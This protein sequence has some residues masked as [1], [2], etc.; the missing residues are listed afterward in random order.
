MSLSDVPLLGSARIQRKLSELERK[1]LNFDLAWLADA[2]PRNG[3][4]V[5]DL[6]QPLPAEPPG[7]PL[8]GGS[9]Q[10]AR[11]LMSGYEFADPSI[12][13]AYYDPEVP[14]ARR[15]ML[16]RL[17]ALGVAHLFAGV[18]VGEVY[19]RT[20]Q[21]AGR[22]AWVWGWN[23]R[24]LEGH[25]EMGQMDW[26]AWKWL[27]DGRVEFRVHAVSRAAHIPNPIIRLGF[28]VLRGPERR[29]F[30]EST[31][32]RMLRFTEL[33]LARADPHST[34]RAA[35]AAAT[36]RPGRDVKAAHDALAQSLGRRN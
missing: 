28:H 8:E 10:I 32:R 9:W 30:L 17:Q 22:T 14:L 13:R 16:L 35:A 20:Q 25:V 21:I 31:K 6:C 7:M 18:R 3:W 34:I 26:E 5:T 2:S 15:N 23:Y 19:E 11:R 29:A 27:D 36:A 33:A 24:T 12:V 4:S 1:P